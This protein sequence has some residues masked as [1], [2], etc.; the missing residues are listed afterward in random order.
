MP[1]WSAQAVSI[2]PHHPTAPLRCLRRPRSSKKM[3]FE[4]IPGA[5]NTSTIH[6]HPANAKTIS[7][8]SISPPHSLGTGYFCV[9]NSFFP[10][11]CPSGSFCP[12]GSCNPPPPLPNLIKF[13]ATFCQRTPSLRII[14]TLPTDYP[15][16]ILQISGDRI[17]LFADESFSF[18]SL[19]R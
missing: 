19:R 2:L 16:S 12:R 1:L 14:H 18:A 9:T 7:H 11:K 13:F 6:L 4:W 15:S 3:K 17:L 10:A 8:I 5:I